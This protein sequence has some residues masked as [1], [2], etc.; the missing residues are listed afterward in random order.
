M[1]VVPEPE[2]RIPSPEPSLPT[3]DP[4]P[5]VPSPEFQTANP[6]S[7][8][9]QV[10][11][12]ADDVEPRPDSV[13]PQAPSP[14]S[15]TSQRARSPLQIA[16]S[17]RNIAKAQARWIAIRKTPGFQPSS[18]YL[19]AT[20]RS[21][22][23]AVAQKLRD[24]SY[25]YAPC[26]RDGMS[27]VSLKRSLALAGESLEEY[28]SHVDFFQQVFTAGFGPEPGYAG[29]AGLVK[30]ATALGYASWR[31]RRGYRTLAEWER[32][33][34][35][36]ELR[37]LA[38][39]RRLED[40]SGRA[41]T[42]E[43]LRDL[44]ISLN[45]AF[46]PATLSVARKIRALDRRFEA[47]LTRTLLERGEEPGFRL[48]SYPGKI[49][50]SRH[51]HSAE[52]LGNPLVPAARVEQAL[53]ARRAQVREPAGWAQFAGGHD[54]ERERQKWFER[55]TLP[56][57]HQELR[58][59]RGQEAHGSKTE[60]P[61]CFQEFLKLV[62]AAVE[63]EGAPAAS[64]E[65]LDFAESL[66]ARLQVFGEQVERETAE[67]QALRQD[68]LN[69]LAEGGSE[70]LSPV[71]LAGRLVQLFSGGERALRRAHA[72]EYRLD[73]AAYRLLVRRF[74]EQPEFE[75]LKPRKQDTSGMLI[76][77]LLL[78]QTGNAEAA[79]ELLALQEKMDA[80]ARAP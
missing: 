4:E 9:D 1:E 68:Y 74:G 39:W 5:P 38:Q 60:L 33:T 64:A 15:P 35:C 19:A 56:G 31:R 78:N 79:E 40:G 43:R 45:G 75:D 48:R 72:A 30:L 16:A 57:E 32:L 36:R 63:E 58:Q 62:Q 11:P 70:P 80:V 3:P 24:D 59:A 46:C 29:D 49:V 13:E 23:A 17:R 76:Q 66:W 25:R 47:L 69:R 6:Q 51:L 34:V 18:Q 14:A 71:K 54:A 50:A 26:F 52:V 77:A 42:A 8:A 21:L 2:L 12:R 37:E 28:Q 20:H 22:T 7:Q 61:R 67:L 10:E 44:V 41:L 73:W 53:G 27:A 65:A 55:R